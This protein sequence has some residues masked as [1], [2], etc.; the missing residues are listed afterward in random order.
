MPRINPNKCAVPRCGS[1]DIAIVYLN[2]PI[3]ER[4]WEK[5]MGEKATSGNPLKEKLGIVDEEKKPAVTS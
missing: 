5:Y 1:S 4:C 2:Y 3:C